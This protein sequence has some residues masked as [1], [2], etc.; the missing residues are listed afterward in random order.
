MKIILAILGFIIGNFLGIVILAIL[1][2]AT[3]SEM[4]NPFVL[5]TVLGVIC[6]IIGFNLPKK[7]SN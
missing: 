6:S 7:K 2:T 1:S 3:Q 5:S 4:G